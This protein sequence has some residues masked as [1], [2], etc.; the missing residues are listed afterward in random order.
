VSPRPRLPLGLAAIGAAFF[1]GFSVQAQTTFYEAWETGLAQERAGAWSEARTSFQRAK[2][3]HPEPGQRVRSYGLNFIEQYDPD[4]HLAR[5]AIRL[6]RLDEAKTHLAAAQKAGVS[7]QAGLSGLR[8]ELEAAAAAMRVAAIPAPPTAAAPLATALPAPPPPL[9]PPAATAVVAQTLP[10]PGETGQRPPSAARP[11]AGPKATASTAA[12][13]SVAVPAPLVPSPAASLPAPSESKPGTASSAEPAKTSDD[14]GS[15][16]TWTPAAVGVLL[17]SAAGAILFALRRRRLFSQAVAEP[18]STSSD[19]DSTRRSSPFGT[20]PTNVFD[21]TA[22]T[23]ASVP[24]GAYVLTGVLGRGAMGSTWL[25][26][27]TRDELAVAIKIPHEHILEQE[28]FVTRFRREGSLGATLYHPNIVRILEAGEVDGKPFIAMELLSGETL[29]KVLR[30]EKRLS[31]RHALEAARGIALALDYAHMKGIV[32]RDLKPDNIM[33]L[34][35][36]TVKVMD[37]GIARQADLTALTGSFT[38]LGTP[39][40]ASPEAF[41]A[42][43]VDARS[44]LYSLGIVLYRMLTGTL[45][46]TGTHTLEVLHKHANEPLPPFPPELELPPELFRLVFELTAKLKDDRFQSAEAF[47]RALDLI[48]N[49]M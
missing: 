8:S 15:G 9:V 49:R 44:D 26:R 22:A 30:R 42:T 4:L 36:G 3:L 40:Y 12:A 39:L 47:L 1:V 10:E 41:H 28:D 2:A 24:F 43:D 48:L 6:G 25:A 20:G 33:I 35:D 16:R 23:R 31:P 13:A 32:H 19:S 18:S 38:F 7:S 14:R 37:Y 21:L 27:R 45:P 11:P 29:E 17:L 46:F 34:T 5:T